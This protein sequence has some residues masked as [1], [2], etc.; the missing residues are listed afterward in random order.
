MR[1]ALVMGVLA[2]GIHNPILLI[3]CYGVA[4]LTVIAVGAPLIIRGDWGSPASLK[5]YRAL[6]THAREILQVFGTGTATSRMEVFVLGFTG[7]PKQLGLYGVGMTLAMV[8]ELVASYVS[9]V[10]APRILTYCRM[11]IFATFYH[12]VTRV[13][14]AI[15]ITT[16]VAAF[17]LTGPAVR[18]IFP[19]SYRD[20]IPVIRVL[21]PGALAN[22][23]LFPLTLNFL[24][25]FSPRT[26]VRYDLA[27]APLLFAAYWY[28]SS[29]HGI[30]GL[31]C[32][33]ASGRFIKTAFIQTKAH[34]MVHR[35]SP[36][37]PST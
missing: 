3:C 22:A 30:F 32:A 21:V 28:A 33:A 34:R 1:I 18:T 23:V 26:F 5:E 11:G 13:V 24:V 15:A 12:R 31:A 37:G 25:F 16:A 4:P 19:A 20:A 14:Y 6:F 27:A 8:P 29:H 7:N 9:A 17:L 2:A 36:L 35:V 10:F